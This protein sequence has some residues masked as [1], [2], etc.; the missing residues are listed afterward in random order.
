MIRRWRC[1]LVRRAARRRLRFMWSSEV[2]YLWA[3]IV[4]N[5]EHPPYDR[6]QET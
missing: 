2:E 3:D 5:F 6:E 4:Q 1:F